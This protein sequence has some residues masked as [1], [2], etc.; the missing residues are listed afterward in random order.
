MCAKSSWIAESPWARALLNGARLS[1]EV[2]A[3]ADHLPEHGEPAREL[4]LLQRAQREQVRVLREERA[5]GE[6]AQLG[7]GQQLLHRQPTH[8]DAVALGGV[9]QGER[10]PVVLGEVE[11]RGAQPED[12]DRREQRVRRLAA[13]RARHPGGTRR[14]CRELGARGVSAAERHAGERE[15][16]SRFAAERRMTEARAIGGGENQPRRAGRGVGISI[17]RVRELGHQRLAVRVAHVIEVLGEQVVRRGVE[18]I[19]PDP[20]EQP[21]AFDP[22]LLQRGLQGPTAWPRPR[23]P[24]AEPA[25][26]RC[27]GPCPSRPAARPTP[28]P[29]PP[30]GAGRRW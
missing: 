8:Q 30:A 10:R 16:L 27:S 9:D 26:P 3:A 19:F 25:A 23:P 18:R 21:G 29:P 12:P 4:L 6:E 14:G 13:R 5:A 28:R 1:G 15:Q 11:V 17:Q 2:A 20:R 7:L 22:E 24:R